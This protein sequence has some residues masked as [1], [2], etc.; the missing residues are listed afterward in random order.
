MNYAQ[1]RPGIQS[2]DLISTHHS[3]WATF[4]DWQVQAV[5]SFTQSPYAHIAQVAEFGGRLFLLEAVSPFVRMVPLS[6][7]AADGFFHIAMDAPMGDAETDKAMEEVASVGYSKGQA[8][9]AF[10]KR[11]ELGPDRLTE[12]AEYVITNRRLSG[13][14]LGDTATPA[15]VVQAAL[16]M[17]KRLQFVRG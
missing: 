5:Q 7:F 2:G 9:L 14:D 17:G 1:A 8:V 12:C 16:D 11:L 3:T 6:H 4:Y 13:V 10:L 15:A